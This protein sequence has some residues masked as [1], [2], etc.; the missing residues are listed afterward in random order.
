MAGAAALRSAAGTNAR[1]TPQPQDTPT[2]GGLEIIDDQTA[3]YPGGPAPGG[4]V[5]IALPVAEV[6][7][8]ERLSPVT[9]EQHPSVLW[10]VHEPLLMPDPATLEPTPWLAQDFEVSSDGLTVTYR[11][12]DD[13]VWHDGNRFTATDAR[14]SLFAYRDDPA[15]AVRGFFALMDDA[16]AVDDLTLR[17]IL[18]GPDVNWLLN[19]STQPIFQ[20]AQYVEYWQSRPVGTRTLS[21]FNW[22]ESLPIGTGPWRF[23]GA[24]DGHAT[25]DAFPDYWGGAPVAE[26][27]VFRALPDAE[28]RQVAWRDGKVEL[29]AQAPAADL[30]ALAAESGRAVLVSAPSVYLAAFNFANSARSDPGL[31]TNNDLRRALS[32]ALDRG[33]YATAVFGGAHNPERAGTVAQP[34]AYDPA[35]FN[36]AFDQAQAASLLGAA[37]LTGSPGEGWVHEGTNERL[38]LTAI[39]SEADGPELAA[40]MAEVQ[41]DLEALGIPCAIETLPP[42]DFDARWRE[43]REWDLMA[44]SYRLF[45]G[46]TDMDLYGSAWDIRNNPLGFNP[47]GYRNDSADAAIQRWLEAAPNDLAAQRE[48]L[49]ELQRAVDEDLFGLWLG[50][51]QDVVI[52]RPDVVGYELNRFNLLHSLRS[53]G[54]LSAE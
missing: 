7:N 25:L 9:Y 31:L 3:V 43:S 39:L 5:W 2:A 50:H 45:P 29:I 10:S 51:G 15:G 28:A 13:V 38:E 47:G 48:S 42:D 24:E 20:R 26:R 8:V 30:A 44:L 4:E 36:P 23:A 16:E 27:L 40:L 19:A 1:R 33:R 14:F 41:S 53:V 52:L 6:V 34:W 18:L 32:S 35:R 21:G 54:R 12:R 17:V 22:A 11:L 37:G 49:V 46:F